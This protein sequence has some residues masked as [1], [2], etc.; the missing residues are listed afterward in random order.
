MRGAAELEAREVLLDLLLHR[1]GQLDPRLLEEAD[2]DHF[3]IR[4][5]DADVE[6]G[7]EALRLQQVPVDGG[8][9]HAEVG[10]VDAGRVEAGDH[11]PLDHPAAGRSLAAA[12]DAVAALERRAE[13]RSKPHRDLGRDVD[14]DQTGEAISAPEARGGTRLPDDALRHLCARLDLLVRVDAN[15]GMDDAL[16]AEG[17]LVAD[18]GALL[19][20]HVRADVAA[21]PQNRAFDHRAAAHVGR[22]VDDAAAGPGLLTDRDACSEHRVWGDRRP[23]RDPGVVAHE[24]GPL[25]LLEVVEL[26]PLPQPDV[27]A[28]TDPRHVQGDR[29]VE[30]V[31]VRLPELV[32]VA[33][34]LPV[35]VEHVAVERPAHLEQ[36]RE[37]LLREVVW[38]VARHV[39]EHLRL[40]HVDAGVDRVREDLAPGGLLEETLDPALVVGDDDPELERVLDRFQPDRHRRLLLAVEGDDLLEVHV[41]QRVSRDD[42]E[43]VVQPPAGEADRSGRAERRLLDRVLDVDAE[44]LTV[45][46]VAADRLRQEGDRDDHVLHAVAAEELDDVLHARLADDGHHRLRLVRRERAQARALAAGHHDR[47]H[48]STTSR[49]A[50]AR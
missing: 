25:D 17:D 28:Q 7:V 49:F 47:L 40:E 23:G 12:D 13:R 21:A 9:K 34:V 6:A 37:E 5:V 33:D 16:R 24:G 38:P 18:R 31:E 4:V 50:F 20:E 43:G 46:E 26:D 44:R 30:R 2:L 3:G 35:L 39:P 8:R 29:L 11:R 42:D 1:R 14:V 41:R 45:A 32:E 36:Q 19:D 15:A 22:R 10:D 27:S 48:A